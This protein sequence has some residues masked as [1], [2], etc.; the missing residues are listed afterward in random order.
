MPVHQ[1]LV[2]VAPG[3]AVTG[4]AFG[5][6]DLLRRIDDSEIFA[7][8]IHPDLADEVH[9]LEEYT[10]RVKGPADALVYHAAIGDAYVLGFLL[11]RREPL[12]LLYHN[13]T[14]AEHFAA[15]DPT[16]AQLLTAGRGDLLALRE[17]VALPLAVSAFNAAELVSLGYED[18][19]VAPLPVDAAGLSEVEPDAATLR[20]LRDQVGGPIVLFVGQLLPHKR[21]DLLLQAHHVLRTYLVPEA[22]LV[23]VGRARQARYRR[24]LEMFIEELALDAHITGWVTGGALVAL[25]RAAACFVTMSEHEGF[26]VPLLEAMALD[27][28]V[29]ARD[30]AAVPET[31]GGAG[32]LLP[33][34]EAPVLAAEAI[35]QVLSDDG[36]RAELIRRGRRRVEAFRRESTDAVFLSHLEA[37]L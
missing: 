28:P 2:T 4:A 36:L 20:R 5:L 27:V 26:C 3:D 1:V 13:I 23:L 37:V 17:R 19:R 7:R 21:P 25:Y 34:E 32:V 16:F 24:G 33:A 22:H 30:F 9:P 29:V 12:V 11:E 8:F 6:R 18:V 15:L 35:S 10:T 31:M 14:P